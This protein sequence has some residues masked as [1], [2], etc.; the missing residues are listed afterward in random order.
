MDNRADQFWPRNPGRLTIVGIMGVL[1]VNYS[2]CTGVNF[3]HTG[4]TH[5]FGDILPGQRHRLPPRIM[6]VLLGV[7]MLGSIHTVHGTGGLTRCEHSLNAQLQQGIQRLQRIGRQVERPMKRDRE[8]PS[9]FDKPPAQ[10][11]IDATVS[12]KPAKNDA[13]DAKLLGNANVRA[14]SY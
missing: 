10:L 2:T 6:R 5:Q 13:R 14:A 12:T 3:K 7:L 8:G 11:A 1:F 4:C 9:R